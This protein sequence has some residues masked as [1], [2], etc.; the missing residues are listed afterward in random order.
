[1][2]ELCLRCSGGVGCEG[3]LRCVCSDSLR[4]QHRI[5]G[6][7]HFFIQF[8]GYITTGTLQSFHCHNSYATPM[9]EYE[10]SHRSDSGAFPN[11]I[12]I[13]VLN[14]CRTSPS[15]GSSL[16]FLITL[17]QFNGF[18]ESYYTMLKL[19]YPVVVRFAGDSFPGIPTR[20]NRKLLPS[21]FYYQYASYRLRQFTGVVFKS[22]SKLGF[23]T[24]FYAIG[25]NFESQD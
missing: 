9:I 7:K 14:S 15:R 22:W 10:Y 21:E 3:C 13:N 20:L 17:S 11:K 6:P 23:T 19:R 4:D 12:V 24:A 18:F 16:C 2:C 1:M 5:I 8:P 25:R